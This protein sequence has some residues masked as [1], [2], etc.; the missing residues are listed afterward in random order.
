MATIIT[1]HTL[2]LLIAAGAP[3]GDPRNGYRNISVGSYASFDSDETIVIPE[4]INSVE[5]LV[6]CGL[7]LNIATMLYNAYQQ[8]RLDSV[9]DGLDYSDDIIEDVKYYVRRMAERVG[10]ASKA[11]ENWL[12]SLT[13]MG[14]SHETACRIVNPD[15][16]DIRLRATAMEWAL[17]TINLG[18]EFLLAL[19]NKIRS[20]LLAVDRRNESPD[21]NI[22]PSP[23][24][25]PSRHSI[26]LRDAA[27]EGSAQ[28]QLYSF[29]D[30]PSQVSGRKMLL[31]GG[32][33]TRM[34]TVFNDNGSLNIDSLLSTPPTDFH[35]T[36]LYLYFSEQLE[37]AEK[38][39]R[40]VTQRVPAEEGAILYVAIDQELLSA[41]AQIINP[42]WRDLIWHSRND[43]ARRST[44]GRLPEQLRRYE[45]ADV[46]IGEI[47]E[48]STAQVSRMSN[49]S[50]IQA[51]RLSSGGKASQTVFQSPTI[52]QQLVDNCR[53]FVWV[54]ALGSRGVAKHYPPPAVVEAGRH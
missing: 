46:L 30:I 20:K 53:G 4:K 35:P 37:V 52:I 40:Y 17:D 29:V 45:D 1:A 8:R 6:F 54:E 27:H 50:E 22:Q 36:A 51:S 38:Y 9:S 7:D 15:F 11:D 49:M 28:P 43:R 3:F 47:C 31:K 13:D 12:K 23:A 2:S 32:A 24:R 10:D 48:R 44:R 16:L 39:A 14:I 41:S 19:D 42:D 5:S 25:Q 21:P 34:E 33:R 26:N 18:W